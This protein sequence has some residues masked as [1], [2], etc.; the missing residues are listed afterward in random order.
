MSHRIVYEQLAI[1]FARDAFP[2]NTFYED[3][4]LFLELGGDNNVIS[5]DGKGS[6]SWSVIAKGMSWQV[7]QEIVEFS[8]GCESGSLQPRGRRVHAESYIA[9]ARRVLKGAVNFEDFRTRGGAIEGTISVCPGNVKSFKSSDLE[10]LTALREYR[11]PANELHTE[12]WRFDLLNPTDHAM[13]VENRHLETAGRSDRYGAPHISCQV[14][15]KDI[16]VIVRQGRP[17]STH[18]GRGHRSLVGK[19]VVGHQSESS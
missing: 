11:E 2:G 15:V 4:Y 16:G 1:T 7:M 13:F 14:T 5:W 3:Q 10:R 17:T 12:T 6:R 8:A 19:G 9:A 18:P